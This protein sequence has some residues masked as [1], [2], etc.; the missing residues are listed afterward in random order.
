MNTNGKTKP[1]TNSQLVI[2][3]FGTTATIPRQTPNEKVELVANQLAAMIHSLQRDRNLFREGGPTQ[4]DGKRRVDEALGWPPSPHFEDFASLYD[5]DPVSERLIDLKPN[6]SWRNGVT[7]IDGESQTKFSKEFTLRV[8]KDNLPPDTPFIAGLKFLITERKFFHFLWRAD[9][10]ARIG[11]YGVLLIATKGAE[12]VPFAMPIDDNTLGG[13]EDVLFFRAFSEGTADIGRLEHDTSNKRFDLPQFYNIDF[14]ESTHPVHASRVVHISENKN[15]S[16]IRGR[17]T[18]RTPY[19]YILGL[20]MII[21]GTAEAVWRQAVKKIFVKVEQET[22]TDI[23]QNDD[24]SVDL[25]ALREMFEEMQ[26]GFKSV[27]VA[28]GADMT[29]LDAETDDHRSA[30]EMHIQV[31]SGD[32][33]FSI[34]IGA[35]A[36]ALASST[37]DQRN[38]AGVIT[39]RLTHFVEP[40]ILRETIGRLI[41]MGALPEPESGEYSFKWKPLFE[42]TEKEE[43]EIGLINA[44][45]QR[46]TFD[47]IQYPAITRW[48]IAG[49]ENIG[50]SD[51]IQEDAVDS[52]ELE[53]VDTGEGAVA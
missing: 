31:I 3:K 5:R 12:G 28:Q 50:D 36:G 39:S 1:I 35:P 40:E 42:L 19:N 51:D 22:D 4:F 23:G 21:G 18:L 25:K 43:A 14:E 45:A 32:I 24:D 49:G 33:P 10:L 30:F 37:T 53:R 44:Q 2:D 20:R 6:D 13:P 29:L 7:I 17:S 16:E 15:E 27:V 34:F 47:G 52:A 11:E 8:G 46:I 41:R 26:H 9:R 48:K 38:W